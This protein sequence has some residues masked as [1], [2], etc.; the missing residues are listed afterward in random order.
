MFKLGANLLLENYIV[1]RIQFE[2]LC[3]QDKEA[4]RSFPIYKFWK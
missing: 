2:Q 4:F 3:E 1:A